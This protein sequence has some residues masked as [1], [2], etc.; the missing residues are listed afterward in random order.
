MFSGLP[1]A[2]IR[3]SAACVSPACLMRLTVVVSD[4]A[5]PIPCRAASASGVSI[6]PGLV[7]YAQAAREP[8]AR[9]DN[10]RPHVERFLA[11]LR[12]V[13]QDST[14]LLPQGRPFRASDVAD[15]VGVVATQVIPSG[16]MPRRRCSRAEDDASLSRD[17]HRRRKGVG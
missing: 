11:N 14:A 8:N 13:G 6:E 15:A 4:I 12:A 3:A 5:S 9:L 16:Y 10:L 2:S 17:E 1:S 7:A